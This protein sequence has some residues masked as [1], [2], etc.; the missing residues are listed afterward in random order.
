MIYEEV[1]KALNSAKIKYIVVGGIALVLHGVVRFTAD[2]DLMV[3]LD[4]KNLARFVAVMN[5]L[6]YRPRIQVKAD[7]I[8]DADKREL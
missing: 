4:N 6:G 8:L 3:K 1:F 5:K 7:E 2:L